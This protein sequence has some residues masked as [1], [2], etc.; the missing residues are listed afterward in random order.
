MKIKEKVGNKEPQDALIMD[1]LETSL[2]IKV[3]SWEYVRVIVERFIKSRSSKM[4]GHPVYFID[5]PGPW[6]LILGTHEQFFNSAFGIW[7]GINIFQMD[8]AYQSGYT[9]YGGP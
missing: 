4:F 3:D 8:A 5:G 7:I 2:D 1:N 9:K 6:I